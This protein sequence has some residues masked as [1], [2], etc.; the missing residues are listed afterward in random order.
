MVPTRAQGRTLITSSVNKQGQ[1]SLVLG[2][3]SL[4][5]L[6]NWE[7]WKE[8][9]N[10]VFSRQSRSESGMRSGIQDESRPWCLV[11]NK[12]LELLLLALPDGEH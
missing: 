10:R 5:I 12:K 7:I 4:I 1:P 6:K 11:G 3:R 2:L 8:R 9:K